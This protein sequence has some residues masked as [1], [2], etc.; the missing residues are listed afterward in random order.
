MVSGCLTNT[1]SDDDDLQ[2]DK[3][4]I[5]WNGTVYQYGRLAEENLELP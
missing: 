5:A 3:V 1:V 4:L 2:M